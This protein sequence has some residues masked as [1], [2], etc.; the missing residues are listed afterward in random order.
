MCS[1]LL[2]WITV[3]NLSYF[4]VLKENDFQNNHF[5]S[6]LSF[7]Y[8]YYTS[9]KNALL[10]FLG[11]RKFPYS[12]FNSCAVLSK[13]WFAMY[14]VKLLQVW[15]SCFS[16]NFQSQFWSQVLRKL[17]MARF[18]MSTEDSSVVPL[19]IIVNKRLGLHGP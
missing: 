7:N 15:L 17:K 2:R 16:N 19:R 10:I 13:S 11:N 12:A 6:S 14:F 8:L 5:L 18:T 4:V 3:I 1:K 9:M